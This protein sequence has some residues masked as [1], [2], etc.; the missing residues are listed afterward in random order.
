MKGIII[1]GEKGS[2]KDTVAELIKKSIQ[3]HTIFFNIGDLVRNMAPVF[4]GTDKWNGCKR[5]FYVDTAKKLKELDKDFLNYYT[6]GK[7]LE[8]F[9]VNTL[10]EIESN[11]LVIITGGRTEEDYSFWKERNF[12]IVGVQCCEEIR[13]QRLIGRDGYLQQCE[14]SLE[15]DTKAIIEKADFIIE[16]SSALEELNQVIKVFLNESKIS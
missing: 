6:L 10:K 1:F 16:N 3:K 12:L 13:Q 7:I 14:D 15:R 5:E 9:K 4:L 2:G 11:S 8:Y